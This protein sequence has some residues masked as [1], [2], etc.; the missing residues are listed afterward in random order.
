VSRQL[1]RKIKNA[2]TFGNIYHIITKLPRGHAYVVTENRGRV[3]RIA[4]FS[5]R[6]KW[7]CS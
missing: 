6:G 4:H 7:K 5:E 2:H 1:H 3:V